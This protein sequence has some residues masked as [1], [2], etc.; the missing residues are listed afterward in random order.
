MA[1]YAPPPSHTNIDVTKRLGE[2]KITVLFFYRSN[3]R[4]DTE[5]TYLVLY[6]PCSEVIMSIWSMWFLHF[7]VLA[8]AYRRVG[9]GGLCSIWHVDY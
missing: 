4:T 6:Q 9:G 2:V 3:A 1:K 5:L 7:V 8:V